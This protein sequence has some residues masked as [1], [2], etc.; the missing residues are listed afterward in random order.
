MMN[1]ATS[2]GMLRMAQL[3][4]ARNVFARSTVIMGTHNVTSFGQTQVL[5]LYCIRI[6]IHIKLEQE[7][8]EGGEGTKRKKKERRGEKNKKDL[9]SRERRG[10]QWRRAYRVKRLCFLLC[11]YCER[12]CSTAAAAASI[13][14]SSTSLPSSSP[15]A[16]VH[17]PHSQLRYSY[18]RAR[19]RTKILATMNISSLPQITNYV[20][21]K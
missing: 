14:S 4:C 13:S 8:S 11:A 15:S 7:N 17:R 18:S 19:T 5:D 6:H 2:P 16:P 3:E 1:H 9:R 21:H 20:D 12:S 10:E